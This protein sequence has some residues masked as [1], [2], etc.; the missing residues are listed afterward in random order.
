MS[1]PYGNDPVWSGA[2]SFPDS[3]IRAIFEE[4]LK[5]IRPLMVHAIGDRTTTS[6]IKLMEQTGG[7]PAWRDKRVRIEHGNG[8]TPGLMEQ[9]RNLGVTVVVNPT[10]GSL[11]GQPDRTMLDAGIPLA[12]G[13]DAPGSSLGEF[14][15]LESLSEYDA[16]QQIR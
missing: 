8:I 9:V 16:D 4:S 14:T 2:I 3:E 13:S 1:K 15:G 12:I 5:T 10:H 7:A 11:P 6:F